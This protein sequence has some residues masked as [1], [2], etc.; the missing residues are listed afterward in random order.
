MSKKS[1]KFAADLWKAWRGI[2]NMKLII[3]IALVGC[4]IIALC[5]GVI[6]RHDHTFRSQH[7]H[8][9]ERMKKDKIHCAK[10]QD[11]EERRKQNQ[12][13]DVKKL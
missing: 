12:K 8:E 2:V 13:I 5:V 9:N 6:F 4:A 1:S 11:L 7:V 10:A 3:V